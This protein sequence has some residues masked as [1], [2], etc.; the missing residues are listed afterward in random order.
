MKT[1]SK[2]M[3]SNWM[4]K[5][6]P[7]PCQ[8]H[9]YYTHTHTHTHTAFQDWQTTSFGVRADAGSCSIQKSSLLFLLVDV[10]TADVVPAAV[11]LGVDKFFMNSSSSSD[12]PGLQ[13]PPIGIVMDSGL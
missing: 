6:T 4:T 7:H 11:V 8:Q 3:T 5:T 12:W 1:D 2:T 9:K 10:V 13:T